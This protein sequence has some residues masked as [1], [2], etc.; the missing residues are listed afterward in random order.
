MT[1]KKKK[2]K[3]NKNVRLEKSIDSPPAPVTSVAL[4]TVLVLKYCS[5][6]RTRAR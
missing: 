2:Q 3:P 1:S 4:T 5:G 6:A